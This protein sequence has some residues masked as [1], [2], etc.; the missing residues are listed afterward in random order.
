MAQEVEIEAAEARTLAKPVRRLQET[1]TRTGTHA[2][3]V[4]GV[5]HGVLADP[6][7]PAGGAGVGVDGRATLA[8]TGTGAGAAA[9]DLP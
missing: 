1:D 2:K 7:G 4:G 3:G 8:G 9:E 6:G 5:A